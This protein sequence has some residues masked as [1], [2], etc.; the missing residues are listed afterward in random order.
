MEQTLG[1]RQSLLHLVVRDN[2][3]VGLLRLDRTDNDDYEIS[4]VT[5]PATYRQGIGLAALKLARRF[6][7]D[8]RLVGQ[9]LPGNEPSRRLFEKAGFRAFGN[10]WFAHENLHLKA[11]A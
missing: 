6:L 5:D 11:S 2:V 3:S 10:G 1:S 8:A 4:I 7:P 9:I